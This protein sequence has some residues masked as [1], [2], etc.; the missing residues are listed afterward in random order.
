MET[1]RL[2]KNIKKRVRMLH[3]NST[4]MIYVDEIFTEEIKNSEVGRICI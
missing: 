4:Q 1:L 3:E 2:L